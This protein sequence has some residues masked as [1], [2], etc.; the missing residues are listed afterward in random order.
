MDGYASEN[1]KANFKWSVEPK[2]KLIKIILVISGRYGKL[3]D[4]IPSWEGTKRVVGKMVS[5]I[6]YAAKTGY[7]IGRA[8][9]QGGLAAGKFAVHYPTAA[10]MAVGAGAAAPVVYL[11]RKWRGPPKKFEL[12]RAA[13]RA[14]GSMIVGQVAKKLGEKGYSRLSERERKIVDEAGILA[15]GYDQTLA[16][17]RTAATGV[18][19]LYQGARELSSGSSMRGNMHMGMGAYNLTSGG[20]GAALQPAEAYLREHYNYRIPYL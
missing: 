17:A 18:G 12:D 7:Q 1:T 4:Y 9:A 19:Q 8:A 20:S 14:T 6:T 2:K 5:P 15:S 10:V 16:N 11:K 13:E 3:G